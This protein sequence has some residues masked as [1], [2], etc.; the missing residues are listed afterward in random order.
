MLLREQS[1]RSDRE[2]SMAWESG[3]THRGAGG[4]AA[5]HGVGVPGVPLAG[6][7]A[8]TAQRQGE[9]LIPPLC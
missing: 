4:G 9:I 8:G 7:H 3:R 5:V 1:T 6:A 2:R